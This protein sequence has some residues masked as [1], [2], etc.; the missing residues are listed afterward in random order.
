MQAE[1]QEQEEN[2]G[3]TLMFRGE[4]G[5][6]GQ[7]A[8]FEER[9]G[10]GQ[11]AT[12]VYKAECYEIVGACFAVYK[13]KGCG[14]LE[15]VYQECLE[16]ELTAREV[17]YVA[18]AVLPLSYRGQPLRQTYQPDFVCYNCIIVELKAVTVL[19]PEHRAQLVNYLKATQM[20]LGLL[21]NFGH[22]PKLEYERIVCQQ[23]RY[24]S[25]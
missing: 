18:Q 8:L 1:Q 22:Y 6:N 9:E 21:I 16:I 14:F 10:Y 19:T 24:S 25:S 20:E 15:A 12:L 13:E 5:S 23:A 11:N 17:P 3:T 4:G 7:N 2:G